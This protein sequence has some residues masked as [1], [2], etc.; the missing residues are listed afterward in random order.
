[1]SDTPRTLTLPRL[2]AFT[3]VAFLG[4]VLALEGGLRI[5]SVVVGPQTHHVDAADVPA[6]L[7]NAIRVVAVGDSWVYGAE[8]EPDE[9]FIEVFRTRVEAA[10]GSP[11]QVYNLGVSASNSAQALVRL[12]AAIETAQPHYVVALTG[13]N[14]LLHDRE[15]AEAARLMGE[16]ARLVPG[17]TWLSG[18]RVVRLV[19]L[20]WITLWRAP[21]PSATTDLSA[22]PPLLSVAGGTNPTGSTGLP[23]APAIEPIPTFDGMP[24]WQ[25]FVRRQWEIGLAQV[26]GAT[27]P[28]DTDAQRGLL[29]AWEALFLAQL[30]RFEEAEAKAA[31]ALQLGGDEAVAHEARA[32]AADRQNRPMEGLQHRLRAADSVDRGHPWIAARA[33]A[34]VLMELEM[35]EPALV[36]LLAVLDAVPGNLEALTAIARLPSAARTPAVE[37]HLSQ[38]PRNSGIRQSE[39][40]EWHRV[41]SGMLDRMAASLGTP[42]PGEVEP[43]DLL[44]AR[45]KLLEATEKPS[46]AAFRGLL[47]TPMPRDRARAYA[48]VVRSAGIP[49]DVEA[50]PLDGVVA[51]ALVAVHRDAG[52]CERA[53]EVGQSGLAAGLSAMD[54]ERA[55]GSC[56]SREVGWSLTEQALGRGPVLDRVAL[57]LGLPAGGVR[58]PVPPPSVPF[59]HIFRE[60]RFEVLLKDP[61]LPDG[62]RAL[63]LAH[64]ERPAEALLVADAAGPTADPSAVAL[65]RAMAAEQR[66]DFR[67]ALIERVRAAEASTGD[68]WL[69]YLARGTAQSQARRWK[70]AQRDLL[71]VLRAAPGYLE[72]LEVLAEVPEQVRF[73]STQTV[74]RWTP[75]G[76]VPQHRWSH[77]YASQGRA[78]ETK[79]A[80]RWPADLVA[81]SPLEAAEVTFALARISLDEGEQHAGLKGMEAATALFEALNRPDRV[82]AVRTHGLERRPDAVAPEELEAL[83]ADCADHPAAMELAGRLATRTGDCNRANVWARAALLAGADPAEM[84]AWVDPCTPTESFEAWVVASVSGPG[85]PRLAT[86]W[87]AERLHPQEEADLEPGGR[88]YSDD[89]LIRHLLAMARLS[90]TED[91]QFLA[92]TYPFPG[93]HHAKVR[94]TIVAASADLPVLDLYA[95]FEA[96]YTDAQWQAIRTPGDHVNALGYAEMGG[97]L[98]KVWFS[99]P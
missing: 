50:P 3:A 77:W 49:E 34:L 42:D 56:L 45:A 43:P 48:G 32:V 86:A 89:L 92:L 75:S 31:L 53:L 71:G 69:R 46:E 85:V 20:F 70:A 78:I 1:M 68:T 57:I 83:A 82:C 51:A 59:W 8:S 19:R 55:A 17:L 61:E 35:W 6:A 38:G 36:W 27:P 41:S 12:H 62:W 15:T 23:S 47:D 87:M 29:A 84:L 74:L 96:T 67:T 54:F 9:A 4:F 2:F 63:A 90:R 7:P 25:A 72:A 65:A 11:V 80:L 93:A 76:S 40:F 24:W 73:D 22:A 5:A 37:E 79:L 98:Y 88:T 94:D 58:G 66:G 18:S 44:L 52:N 39:Y 30:D 60:R 91:A 97:V 33:R 26:T 13:A 10:T 21:V 64:L 28:D 14:N 16:D 81:Q 95:H 99:A